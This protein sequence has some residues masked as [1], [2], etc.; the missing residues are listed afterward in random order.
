MVRAQYDGPRW[1]RPE[2]LHLTLV[3]LGQ[4]ESELV[5]S[6]S[7]ALGRVAARHAAHV[8]RTAA[9]GGHARDGHGRQRGGVAWLTLGAGALETESL[10]LDVDETLGS[11]TYDERR[12]PHPHL[13]VARNVDDA[14]LN[15]LR[16]VAPQLDVS[17]M[18]TRLVLFRSHM[19]GSGSQYEELAGYHLRAGSELRAGSLTDPSPTA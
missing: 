12:R 4:T 6:I 13:T 10:A 16:E 5:P 3:F 7:D 1:T 2:L 15:R 11:N 19:G 8:V 17:W 18:T 14:A 9:A